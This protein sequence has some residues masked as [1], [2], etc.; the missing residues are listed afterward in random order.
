M[1]IK[2]NG[3]QISLVQLIC[4]IVY[5]G[6]CTYLP[7]SSFPIF[8]KPSRKLRYLCCKRIFKSCGNNVNIERK[9]SFGNG[10]NVEIGNNS[11]I[12]RYSHIPPNIKIG[13]DVMMAPEVFIFHMNH[14]FDSINVPMRSQGIKD[15]APVI[16]EDDVWIGRNVMILPGKTIKKGSIIAAGCVLTKN[17]SEYSIVGGNPSILIKIRN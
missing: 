15:S 3:N 8:G 7:N 4:L 11:G 14:N 12:G 2:I 1:K 10:L 13:N 6:F 17:F 5:Y 9:A 16:I